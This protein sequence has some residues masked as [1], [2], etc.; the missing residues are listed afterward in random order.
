M[1]YL[2]NNGEQPLKVVPSTISLKLQEGGEAKPSALPT[3]MLPPPPPSDTTGAKAGRV[4]ATSAAVAGAL[5][6]PM[7]ALLILAYQTD[8]E[9]NTPKLQK[10]YQNKELREVTLAKGETAQ[11][12]IY[13]YVPQGVQRTVGAELIVPYLPAKGKGGEVRVRLGSK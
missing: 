10:E 9:R 5:L 11:G 4:V 12:F 7:P 13:F 6:F 8:K 1:V 2:Q 3:E